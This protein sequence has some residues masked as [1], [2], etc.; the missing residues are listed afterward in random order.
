MIPADLKLTTYL[1]GKLGL[2]NI[3]TF[4]VDWTEILVKLDMRTNG[5]AEGGNVIIIS[6][7]ATVYYRES[8]A[9]MPSEYQLPAEVF[10]VDRKTFEYVNGYSPRNLDGMWTFPYGRLQKK[11][12]PFYDFNINSVVA[13]EYIGSQHYY[14][15]D[16]Y[17]YRAKI[18]NASIPLEYVDHI[19]KMQTAGKTYQEAEYVSSVT[20]LEVAFFYSGE[21]IY[22]VEPVTA[23]PIDVITDIEYYVQLPDVSRLPPSFKIMTVMEGTLKIVNTSYAEPEEVIGT[24]SLAQSVVGSGKDFYLVEY[25]IYSVGKG[26]IIGMTANDQVAL[27]EVNSTTYDKAT[28]EP[29]PPELQQ[30]ILLYGVD[31]DTFENNPNY[32][33]KPRTGLFLFKMGVPMKKQN[34]TLWHEEVESPLD[35]YFIR[36]AYWGGINTYV[37]ETMV[38]NYP[39]NATTYGIEL[40]PGSELLLDGTFRYWVEP[41]TSAIIDTYRHTQV[42]LCTGEPEASE[43]GNSDGDD[44]I[45]ELVFE[46][47]VQG[48]PEYTRQW[49]KA[50]EQY[51]NLMKHSEKRILALSIQLH[52]PPE[53]IHSN[54]EKT[55]ILRILTEL[56]KTYLPLIF[57]LLAGIS[58]TIA[59]LRIIHY[60]YERYGQK[61]VT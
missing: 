45:R 41:N 32:G 14:G 53:C 54:I 37:Y 51:K 38:Q 58:C 57:G 3:S 60:R 50:T 34:Y 8:G 10:G 4:D 42:Y 49:A 43:N 25:D 59:V 1:E 22:Y 7:L 39:V 55:A 24:G 46:L 30:P 23:L 33:D 48:T 52:E 61:K 18:T 31:R 17:V 20:D 15:I 26:V 2:L 28:G 11:T 29:L 35:V 5:T 40:P 9:L 21:Y 56:A 44:A 27:I 19:I 36:E 6:N 12:Y 16:V 13:T 47:E